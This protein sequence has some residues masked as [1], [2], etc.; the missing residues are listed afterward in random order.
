MKSTNR[1]F[2]TIVLCIF[3]LWGLEAQ[4]ATQPN[5]IIGE[6]SLIGPN[7]PL[8]ND[9]ITLTKDSLSKLDHP[10]WIFEETN[11]MRIIYYRDNNNSGVPQIAISPAGSREWSYDMNSKILHIRQSSEDHYFLTISSNDK[12]LKLVRTK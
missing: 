7:K 5:L 4:K 3:S 2:L 11:K 9:T 6:W 1:V 8:I 10:S 12:L